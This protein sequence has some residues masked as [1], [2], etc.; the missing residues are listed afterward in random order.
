MFNLYRY[1]FKVNIITNLVIILALLITIL[2]PNTT[3]AVSVGVNYT[4][5]WEYKTYVEGG[6][7]SDFDA[8]TNFTMSLSKQFDLYSTNLGNLNQNEGRV[9]SPGEIINAYNYN[10]EG[11]YNYTSGDKRTPPMD[12]QT[13]NWDYTSRPGWCN[14]T[15]E[16]K[17]KMRGGVSRQLDYT[18]SS[19]DNSIIDCSAG[20]YCVARDK[21]GTATIT[22]SFP[23]EGSY[24]V[25]RNYEWGDR[26]V[27]Y[28]SKTAR[29][30]WNYTLNPISYNVRVE[31]PNRAPTANYTITS[32]IDYNTATTNWEYIDL[33][34]DP[35]SNVEVK[36]YTN[37]NYTNGQVFTGS[38]TGADIRSLNITGLSPGTTYYPRVMARDSKGADSNWS[39]GPAF[40]TRLNQP[41]NLDQLRCGGTS[42]EPNY[43]SAKLEWNY[44]GTDEPGDQLTLKARWKREDGSWNSPV[45]LGNSRSGVTDMNNL[46]SGYRY[47][48]Q[49]YLNDNRNSYPDVT[50]PLPE[51]TFW[52]DCNPVTPP[53]YPDPEFTFQL[54]G[55]GKT[56]N[57]YDVDKK[58]VLKTG[59]KVNANWSINNGTE[60]GLQ[61]CALSTTGGT[62]LYGEQEFRASLVGTGFSGNFNNKQVPTILEDRTYFVK[63]I[64]PGKQA[65]TVK[66][67]DQTINLEV[68]SYPIITNCDV[69]KNTVKAGQTNVNIT[70]Q[71]ENVSSY[72][73]E[74]RRDINDLSNIS[75]GNS[76]IPNPITLN[77]AGTEFGRY[78]PWLK[79]TKSGTTRSD[80]RTCGKVAN[81][82]DSNV[83]E[84]NP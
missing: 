62:D 59:D 43:T 83:R 81:L 17:N 57:Y 1:N 42:V 44:T 25:E 53:N 29:N 10:T 48:I 2:I 80:E 54:T 27:K 6:S 9:I 21:D 20:R 79:V 4:G 58:L 36:V 28:G 31:I 61:S 38:A 64:C 37:S 3:Q 77:Y 13:Y 30:A 69:N 35:Q 47:D 23:G 26:W 24:Y 52:K 70:A 74:V 78:T 12:G 72:S 41:P 66:S 45:T 15:F 11:S 46:V 75:L 8:K 16:V 49:L 63:L 39:N 71:V 50:N 32:N 51:S 76:P 34:G 65:K 7:C 14:I 56:V 84:I 55:D 22:V 60:V 19:T 82:G 40:T 5:S 73:W 67:V 18:L 33:D 68:Q